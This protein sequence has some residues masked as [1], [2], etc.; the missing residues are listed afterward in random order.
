MKISD[1]ITETEKVLGSRYYDHLANYWCSY[2]VFMRSDD[3][4]LYRYQGTSRGHTGR[5]MGIEYRGVDGHVI[6]ATD[7]KLNAMVK[8]KKL[9]PVIPANRHEAQELDDEVRGTKK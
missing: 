1:L 4:K 2:P 6:S 5:G 3:G 9:S 8:E 7:E